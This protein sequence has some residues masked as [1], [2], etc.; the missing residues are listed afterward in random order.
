MLV[1]DVTTLKAETTVSDRL[2]EE[3]LLSSREIIQAKNIV[4]KG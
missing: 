3:M 1:E 2:L 4:A